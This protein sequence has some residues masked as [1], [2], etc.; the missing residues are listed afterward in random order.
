VNIVWDEFLIEYTRST[1]GGWNWIP[2]VT[3]PPIPPVIDRMP[4]LNVTP[5]G[6]P[7]VLKWDASSAPDECAILSV[8]RDFSSP[9]NWFHR[10]YFG[11]LGS[12]LTT[13]ASVVSTTGDEQGSE[14]PG[15]QDQGEPMVYAVATVQTSP[16]VRELCF[17]AFDTL[18]DSVYY[19]TSLASAD[20][21]YDFQA[22]IDYTPGDYVHIAYRD[23]GWIWYRTW[24]YPVTPEMFR[25]PQGPRPEWDAVPRVVSAGMPR[26]QHPSIDADGE[27]VY[28]AWQGPTPNLLHDG[29]IWRAQCP[30]G[31]WP[32]AW[33]GLQLVYESPEQVSDCPQ[34]HGIATTTWQE[35]MSTGENQVLARFGLDV[36]NI[37]QDARYDNTCPQA[38]VRYP[39]PPEPLQIWCH[40]LWSQARI[41]PPYDDS[42]HYR[43]Q[44]WAP[45]DLAGMEYPTYVRAVLGKQERS[46]YCLQRDGCRN[47]GDVAVDYAHSRLVYELPYI[48]PT[49]RYVAEWV[50]YNGESLSIT[51]RVE[52]GGATMARMTL[53]PGA[54]DT[55][56]AVLPRAAY[57]NTKVRVELVREAGPFACLAGSLKLYEKLDEGGRDG[58]QAWSR[59]GGPPTV[60]ASPNP[61]VSSCVFYCP[62]N[63]PGATTASVY[64]AGGR[65]V[66]SL[67]V[68]RNGV[69]SFRADWDGA[70]GSGTS[71]PTGIYYCKFAGGDWSSCAKV[72]RQ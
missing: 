44:C 56:R 49:N 69:G 62:A 70:D 47:Y 1:D 68:C 42:I 30:V 63:A 52:V 58:S 10:P 57:R 39:V 8:W 46:R 36:D 38:A 14:Q 12:G 16:G 13:M 67:A 59:P 29:E 9:G 26:N 37:S 27:W 33:G 48:N 3:V 20:A 5:D 24:H 17:Y 22:S 51:Q 45:R 31:P 7:W 19:Q 65:L 2:V 60:M 11:S 72:V 43:L 6:H 25:D 54:C 53:R 40:T 4:S 35:R 71:V 55:L 28:C 66:R 32:P 18:A 23:G 21:G 61:F 34:C 64:D 50:V 41:G 15:Q